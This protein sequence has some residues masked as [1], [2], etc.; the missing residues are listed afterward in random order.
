M[1]VDCIAGY[2]RMPGMIGLTTLYSGDW[3]RDDFHNMLAEDRF[4]FEEGTPVQALDELNET[5][6]QF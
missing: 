3:D 2:C 6:P 5:H 4:N 1:S